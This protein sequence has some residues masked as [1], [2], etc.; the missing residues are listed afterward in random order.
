MGFDD[1]HIANSRTAEFEQ[2]FSA[3][4]DGAGSWMS[5]SIGLKGESSM[6]AAISA[7]GDSS[8]WARQISDPGEVATRHPVFQYRSVRCISPLVEAGPDRAQ[9]MLGELVALFEYRRACVHS[10]GAFFDINKCR[11][12]ID[13]HSCGHVGSWYSPSPGRSTQNA[14]ADHGR[15]RRARDALARHRVHS[16]R[17][18]PPA[19]IIRSSL[20]PTV[21][22][23]RIR[24]HRR[25]CAV[26]TARATWGKGA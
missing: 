12:R 13:S 2:K 10:S 9:Q 16:S 3:V 25:R 21:V 24:A 5:Y 17:C 19:A 15:Y 8:R 6:L 26:R 4:T 1:D 22:A 23:I 7:L 14:L 18:A 20:R 11:T